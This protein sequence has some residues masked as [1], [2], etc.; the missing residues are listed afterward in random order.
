MCC[1]PSRH[2]HAPPLL[3]TYTAPS[4]PMAAPLGPPP[5]SAIVARLPSRVTRVSVPRRISTST[6][7]PSAIA[8]GPSGNHNPSAK[9][10]SCMHQILKER[11]GLERLR[12]HQSLQQVLRIGGEPAQP[13]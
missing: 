7:D 1:S 12:E 3:Q 5:S 11:R 13:G 8:M 10:L 4:G 9:R 2:S 6:I